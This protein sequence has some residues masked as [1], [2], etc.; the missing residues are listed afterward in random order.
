MA[1]SGADL[2]PQPIAVGGGVL[3]EDARLRR[4]ADAITL[5]GDAVRIGR[6]RAAH[7]SALSGLPEAP[8]WQWGFIEVISTALVYNQL[9]DRVSAA[10]YYDL[11]ERWLNA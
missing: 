2:L 5:A 1:T 3:D 10:P 8:I 9:G 11:A 4:V 6:A 7:L